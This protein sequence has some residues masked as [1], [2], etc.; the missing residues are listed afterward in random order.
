[1]VEKHP[2][3]AVWKRASIAAVA[4]ALL[5]F[6]GCG[7]RGPATGT[8]EGK[9]TFNSQPVTQGNVV[10]ENAERGWAY[11]APLDAEGRYRLAD[12]NLAEYEVCIRPIEPR[13]ADE[14]SSSTGV[15]PTTAPVDPA[16]IPKEFRSS[17]T[18]RLKA[19]VVEGPNPFNYDLAKPQ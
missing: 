2:L 13:V 9:I 12:V 10:Y 3:H 16:N 5:V 1:M 4:C 17:Q 15:I 8:V 18:T 14:T 19:T 6:E 7:S 11:V